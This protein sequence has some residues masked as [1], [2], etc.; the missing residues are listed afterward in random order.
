MGRQAGVQFT[1]QEKTMTS[2]SKLAFLAAFAAASIASPAFARSDTNS[3]S[4][5]IPAHHSG[6]LFD[7]AP[8][9]APRHSSDT[10]SAT[11]GGSIGYN[12]MLYNW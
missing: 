9:N 4:R 5:K 2:V 12:Q 10:P 1:N 7:I 11:G 3:H 6:R 8:Q